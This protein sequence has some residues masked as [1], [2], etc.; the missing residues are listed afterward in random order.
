LQVTP[1]SVELHLLKARLEAAAFRLEDALQ[2]L[3]R[4]GKT[5]PNT[6]RSGYDYL[7]QQLR[8]FYDVAKDLP[9]AAKDREL[10]MAFARRLKSSPHPDDPWAGNFL[11]NHSPESAPKLP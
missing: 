8:E 5:F 3:A 2:T 1:D 4:I 9:N 11:E 7:E 10:Q 6:D